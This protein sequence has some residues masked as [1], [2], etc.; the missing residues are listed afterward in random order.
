MSAGPE[1]MG[2]GGPLLPANPA[3]QLPVLLRTWEGGGVRHAVTV[4]RAL[5]W[6][7]S[8]T[9]R[10]R[11]VAARPAAGG[12]LRP[13]G[14][15]QG[16]DSQKEHHS[17]P[18]TTTLARAPR[19]RTLA[20]DCGGR[21]GPYHPGPTIVTRRIRLQVRGVLFASVLLLFVFIYFLLLG[22]SRESGLRSI[23]S[24]LECTV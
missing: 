1:G 19:L 10:L 21:E 13:C 17:T 14:A 4:S 20:L 2:H 6:G 15:P 18:F 3:H 23:I 5:L 7:R 9:L 12:V 22:S 8:D 11:S 24:F 16:R